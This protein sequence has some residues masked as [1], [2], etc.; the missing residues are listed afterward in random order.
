MALPANAAKRV[1]VA[2][3][4]ETLTRATAAHKKDEDIARQ[5]A[6]MELSER[7]TDRTLGRLNTQF[8]SGS[9]PAMALLLLADRSAFRPACK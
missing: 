5:V 4:E 7:L 2:Q 9:Q 6:S 3:L 8:A 1:T